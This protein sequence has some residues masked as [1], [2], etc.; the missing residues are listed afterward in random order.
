[1]ALLLFPLIRRSAIAS[2]ASAVNSSVMAE[3][4]GTATGGGAGAGGGEG[5]GM[6]RNSHAPMSEAGLSSG[7]P[8]LLSAVS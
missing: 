8:K 7:A 3:D 1:M 2:S 5:V 4:V 6:S